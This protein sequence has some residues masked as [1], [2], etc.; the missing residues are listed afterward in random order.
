METKSNKESLR[1]MLTVHGLSSIIN[2]TPGS[3]YTLVHK[4]SQNL[5]PSFRIGDK[6]LWHPDVVDAWIRAKAGLLS[7]VETSPETQPMKKKRGR[8]TKGEI[9]AKAA[10]KIAGG[11]K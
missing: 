11:Q 9:A 4:K 7:P 5:P 2:F 10:L 1:P 3:I 8:P 6:L